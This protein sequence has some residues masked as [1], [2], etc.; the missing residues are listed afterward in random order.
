MGKNQILTI[1]SVSSAVV[2]VTSIAGAFCCIT[3]K[4]LWLTHW[5]TSTA[6]V[7]SFNFVSGK[8]QTSCRIF[9]FDTYLELI[10]SSP[11]SADY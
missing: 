5:T 8:K 2:T 1:V 10:Y 9:L 4:R 3:W 11:A 6:S 7:K